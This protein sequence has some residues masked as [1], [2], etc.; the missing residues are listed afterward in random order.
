MSDVTR[1]AEADSVALRPRADFKKRLAQSLSG[2]QVGR[3]LIK[4]AKADSLLFQLDTTSPDEF[5]KVIVTAH[6][7]DVTVQIDVEYIVEIEGHICEIPTDVDWCWNRKKTLWR[8]LRCDVEAVDVC[9]MR[10]SLSRLKQIAVFWGFKLTL[11]VNSRKQRD[12]IVA[13]SVDPKM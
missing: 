6:Q 1:G 9:L 11:F 7:D 2:Q 4:A 8:N 13:F 5:E 12:D 3:D 10:A